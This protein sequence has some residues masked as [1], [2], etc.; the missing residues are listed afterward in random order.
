MA[1]YIGRRFVLMLPVLLGITVLVFTMIHFA[2][3]DPIFMMLGRE[4]NEEV[5]ADLRAK[6][7]LDKPVYVQYVLWLGRILR[8]D[9]GRSFFNAEQALPLVLNRLLTTITLTITSMIVAIGI[10][11]PLGV[12]SAVRKDTWIDNASRVAAIIA[13]SMPVF[14][15]GLLLLVAFSL[16]LGW[17]PAGGSTGEHGLKALVLPAITLGTGFTALIIRMVRSSMVETLAED[18]VRTARSKGL[19]ET[20]VYYR[21]ALKNALLPVVTI[22]GMQ[23]GFLLSGAVVTETV[24]T[25]PGMGRLFLESLLR[26]DYP[27]IQACILVTTVG[28]VLT[29]LLVDI[30]YAFFDPRIRYG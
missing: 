16:Y 19:E 6:L 7:G 14:W 2:P 11:V 21:H 25:I 13:V 10:A 20:V 4:Y 9:F 23:F 30:L 3:G 12:L 5:A 1:R 22:V 29:N 27:V 18:Y 17:F 28:F 15:F 24:F 8:G 26:R